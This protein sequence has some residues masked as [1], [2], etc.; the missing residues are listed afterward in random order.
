MYDVVLNEDGARE[1]KGCMGGFGGLRYTRAIA[2][3]DQGPRDTDRH[4]NMTTTL[5]RLR[6]P[7]SVVVVDGVGSCQC[8]DEDVSGLGTY[9]VG[10]SVKIWCLSKHA[11]FYFHSKIQ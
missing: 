9:F 10:L 8:L 3:E 4:A 1:N 6:M 11:H 2:N 5:H 7:S